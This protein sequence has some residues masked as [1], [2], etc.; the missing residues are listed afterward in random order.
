M[1]RH[2]HGLNVRKK[3]AKLYEYANHKNKLK[4]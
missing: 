3:Y 4:F 1:S 2:L